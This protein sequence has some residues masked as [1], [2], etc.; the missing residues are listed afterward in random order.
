MGLREVLE[1]CFAGYDKAGGLPSEAE[2]YEET[3]G[4]HG[5]VEIRRYDR[6]ALPQWLEEV[7]PLEGLRSIARVVRERHVGLTVARESV[8]YVISLAA[9]TAFIAQAIRS[10]WEIENSCTVGPGRDLSGG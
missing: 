3:D 10:H 2:T 5:R 4:D 1:E 7:R 6:L 8:F 9:D